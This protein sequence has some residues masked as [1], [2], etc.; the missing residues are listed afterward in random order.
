[1]V[2]KNCAC[3]LA[4]LAVKV[5]RAT[6]S[7][8]HAW[9]I[10]AAY[11]IRQFAWGR[12]EGECGRREAYVGTGAALQLGL[13]LPGKRGLAVLMQDYV[14]ALGV[15]ILGVDEEPVHVEE[16]GADVGESGGQCQLRERWKDQASVL[17]ICHNHDGGIGIC[18]GR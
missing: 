4:C 11:G 7:W 10:S 18:Q 15:D 2:G 5:E 9:K 14:V 1:M 6:G 3:N 17:R 12:G 16:T 8:A 13:D